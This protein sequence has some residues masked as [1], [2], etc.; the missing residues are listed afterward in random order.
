[1]I[2]ERLEDEINMTQKGLVLSYF[3]QGTDSQKNSSLSILQSLVYQYIEAVPIALPYAYEEITKRRTTQGS[4]AKLFEKILELGNPDS[5]VFVLID[6]LD[7][8]PPKDIEFLL[9]NT[10]RVTSTKDTRKRV[11]VLSRRTRDVE[12]CLKSKDTKWMIELRGHTDND[13]EVYIKSAIEMIIEEHELETRDPQLAT[14]I[15]E[16]LISKADGELYIQSCPKTGCFVVSC[17]F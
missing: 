5:P 10:L 14:E 9:K 17:C 11:L 15:A 8:L 12:T 13:L 1:M 4:L 6:G 7:E 2:L 16:T 3:C